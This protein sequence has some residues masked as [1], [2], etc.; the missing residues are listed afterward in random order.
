VL[1][2]GGVLLL[3]LGIALVV[4]GSAVAA[5]LGRDGAIVSAPARVAGTGVAV[6]ADDVTVDAGSLPIPAG[7]GDLTFTVR[8]TAATAVFVGT[9]APGQVD[10]YLTGA[11]YDVV[12][13]LVGGQVA[14]TRKVPGT[15]QPQPPAQQK[16]WTLRASGSPATFGAVPSDSSLVIMNADARPGIDAEVTARFTVRNAWTGAWTAVGAG[17]AALVLAVV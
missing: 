9:A 2:T 6:V 12:V 4:A 16:F 17:A 13:D 14:K 7:M 15:Q 5:V 11:P 1:V 10:A 8:S 3:L